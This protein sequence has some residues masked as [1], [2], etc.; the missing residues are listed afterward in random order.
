M[1]ERRAAKPQSRQEKSGEGG[2]GRAED[3]KNSGILR[4]ASSS[5]PRLRR[6][7]SGNARTPSDLPTFLVIPSLLG[8]LGALPLVFEDR[9]RRL[10]ASPLSLAALAGSAAP[11]AGASA[12]RRLASRLGGRVAQPLPPSLERLAID[13]D[14]AR[15]GAL[16]APARLD[17]VVQDRPLDHVELGARAGRAAPGASEPSCRSPCARRPRRAGSR[18]P[19]ASARRSCRSPRAARCARSRC[20]A[21]ARS[22]ARAGARARPSRAR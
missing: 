9:D 19:R 11:A 13:P 2:T 16:V 15:R 10:R 5:L 1:G 6:A 12:P 21:R 7:A 20:G 8:G 3:R 14:E 22:R 17:R 18:T 4:V